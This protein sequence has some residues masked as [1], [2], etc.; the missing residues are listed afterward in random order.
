MKNK[1]LPI[2]AKKLLL[3]KGAHTHREKCLPQMLSLSMIQGTQTSQVA[4]L[5]IQNVRVDDK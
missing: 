2:K 5:P 4:L 3:I 1:C